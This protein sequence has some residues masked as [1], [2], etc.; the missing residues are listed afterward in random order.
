MLIWCILILLYY[1]ECD[2]ELIL[3]KNI[4]SVD[5]SESFKSHGRNFTSFIPLNDILLFDFKRPQTFSKDMIILL[6][7]R[8][9]TQHLTLASRTINKVLTLF[10][11]KHVQFSKDRIICFSYLFSSIMVCCKDKYL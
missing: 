8:N 9:I 7:L 5:F 1:T 10:F 4:F 3:Y 6:I 11:Y 2:I